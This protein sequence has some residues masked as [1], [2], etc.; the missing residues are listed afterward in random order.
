MDAIAMSDPAE[1]AGVDVVG[2]DDRRLGQ[3]RDVYLVDRTGEVCALAVTRHRLSTR[4]VLLPLAAIDLATLRAL[5][6]DPREDEPRQGHR[7]HSAPIRLLV[8][9][10]TAR[11]GVEPAVTAHADPELLRR[12]AREL[13]LEEHAGG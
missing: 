8:D 1:L 9:A 13:G 6:G 7:E 12:A 10:E 2:A 11:G 5:D 3:V 4:T